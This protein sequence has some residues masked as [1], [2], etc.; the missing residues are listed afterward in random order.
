MG[1]GWFFFFGG[2][3][4]ESPKTLGRLDPEMALAIL[5]LQT[6]NAS[7]TSSCEKTGDKLICS[8]SGPSCPK[9]G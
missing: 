4:V 1:V 9:G 2:G 3:A 5:I 6:Y 7:F 8:W